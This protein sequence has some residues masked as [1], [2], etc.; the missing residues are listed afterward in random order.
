VKD[1]H[2]GVR[3]T[4][5]A[6]QKR[7]LKVIIES[8]GGEPISHLCEKA[9]VSNKVWYRMISHPKLGTLLPEALDYLLGQQLI[10]VLQVIVKKALE[11]S[12]KHAELVLKVSGLIGSEESTKILQVF[13]SKESQ[14]E[15]LSDADINRLL[16]GK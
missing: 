10:P 13:G 8:K 5:T 6:P 1:W 14:G 9:K 12:G 3:H 2:E 16:G 4:L 15:Y 7:L 11:G